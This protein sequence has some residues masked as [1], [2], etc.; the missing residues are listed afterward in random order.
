MI[1]NI[2][3]IKKLKKHIANIG[4]VLSVDNIDIIRKI[5]FMI[6]IKNEYAYGKAS[7]RVI[8]VYSP[9]KNT[10]IIYHEL[11]PIAPYPFQKTY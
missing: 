1:V 5:A 8:I 9:K 7:N 10:A 3:I 6:A 4:Q 11:V 2:I